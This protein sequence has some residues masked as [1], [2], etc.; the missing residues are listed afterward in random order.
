MS[1]KFKYELVKFS[2]NILLIEKVSH[3]S[4]IFILYSQK[5][6][7]VFSKKKISFQADTC[8]FLHYEHLS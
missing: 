5:L 7:F 4:E 1:K 8:L 2:E 6:S 3:D